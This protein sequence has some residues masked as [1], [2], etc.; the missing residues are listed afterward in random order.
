MGAGRLQL[1]T[2][3]GW[4]K[5][6]DRAGGE[7]GY[8]RV[9]CYVPERIQPASRVLIALHGLDR[10]A[11]GFR[12]E[13]ITAADRLGKIVIVPEFDIEAFPG[14]YAYNYG[15]VVTAPPNSQPTVREEW[16][17]GL[18]D[19]LFLSIR[20][21]ARIQSEKFD[22]YGNSAGSQYVLRYVALTEAPMLEKPISSNSGIYMLPNL[23]VNYPDGMGG[24][25]MGDADLRRYLSRPLHILLGDADIDATAA[26]LPRTPEALAQGPH[27]L[28]RGLWHFEHCR[29][30]AKTLGIELAWTVEIVPG[31]HHIS[32]AIFDRAMAISG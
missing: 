10:V 8:V 30:L 6:E 13:F 21:D 17:F 26:D 16:N 32:R 3:A 14:V 2:G 25:G 7:R 27:R 22:L 19:R 4:F 18:I 24:I 9:F 15:N 28:A 5:F 11:A 29:A 1:T 20:N 31:A 23:S 12:D